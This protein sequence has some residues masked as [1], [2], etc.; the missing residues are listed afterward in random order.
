MIS[1]S[2]LIFWWMTILSLILLAGLWQGSAKAQWSGDPKVNTP[3]SRSSDQ[4]WN[5][6]I[7]SDG[8]DG[9]II[10]W[11]NY[12]GSG[13]KYNIKAQRLDAGG[14]IVWPLVTDICTANQDQKDYRVI[15]DGTGGAIVVWGDNRN[16]YP[17]GDIYA[18]RV[19]ASGQVIW[20]VDGVPI[21][22]AADV[23][24]YPDLC[25]DGAGGAIITW[26]DSR[27]YSSTGVDIYAQR[28]NASGVVQ[29][30]SN[31]IAV[32]TDSSVQMDPRIISDGSG[33]AIITWTDDRNS[34]T[35]RDI[36]AQKING[37]GVKQWTPNGVGYLAMT[38]QINP[39]IVSDGSGG[40]IIAWQDYYNGTEDID[41]RALRLTSSG[42]FAW[43][44]ANT[45]VCGSNGNQIGPLAVSDG[46]GGAIIVWTDYRNGTSNPDIY[47]DRIDVNG[48][49]KWAG[50]GKPVCTAVDRQISPDIVSD[51]FGGAIITWMDERSDTADIYA[52][53][54]D[55]NGTPQWTANGLAI[56][57]AKKAQN[58]PRLTRAGT[59][60]AIITWTDLRWVGDPFDDTD[61][62]IY[63]QRVYGNGTLAQERIIIDVPNG[64]ENWNVGSTR[65]IVW[66][67]LNFSDPI[68]IE[69]STDAG[70]NYTTIQPSCQNT[71]SFQWT[72]PN[73]PSTNCCVKISD[74]ADGNPFDIS[75]AVFTISAT[76]QDNTPVGTN[77]EV[78]LGSGV[79]ITFSQVIVAG[80]TTLN[81]N[82]SGPLPPE[83]HD[84][85]PIGS[86]LYYQIETTA[87]YT[88]DIYLNIFYNDTGIEP[89]LEPTLKL[90]K[91]I[92]T[93]A[94]W[95]NITTGI[96]EVMNVI[97]GRTDSLSVFAIMLPLGG[98]GETGTIVTNCD[99][100]G[101]GS[102]RDAIVF[103][104]NNPGPD[105]IRFQIPAGAPGH[106]S[107]IGVWMIVPQS[108]LPTITDCLLIDGFSQ[109]EFIGVDTNPHGPEIFLNGEIA[110]QYA[111]G[112]RSTAGGTEI[113][114]L[115]ISNF[116]NAGI[117]MYGVDGGRISG[118]YVGVDFAANGP[119]ANGYGIWLGNHTHHVT[120]SPYDTFK[121]VISGNTNGGVIVADTSNHIGILGNIIG[122]NRTGEYAIANGN[123]GGIRID[124]QCDSV[125]VFDNWIGGNKFGIY[126]IGSHFITIGNNFIGSNRIGDEILELGNEFD[127]IY[128]C[129][130]AHDN[131]ITENFIRFNSGCGVRI[132]GANT[133][134]NRV[135]HNHISGNAGS[136]ISN[137]SG[138]NLELAPPVIT[139][140]SATSVTGT[141]IPNAMV[142]I[143]TDPEDEGMRF[144]GETSS[145]VSGNFT[146][147]GGITGPFTNITA[148]AIDDQGNTSEF[149]SPFITGILVSA[150][151][152][153]GIPGDTITVPITVADITG[154]EI[155]GLS[156]TIE[157]QT[158]VLIPIGT[159][160]GGTIMEAWG[161]PT[162]QINGGQI[163]IAGA[164]SNPLSGSGILIIIQYQVNATA[165]TGQSTSIHFVDFMFN[166][167][168]PAANP[169]DGWFSIA[170]GFN[171]S[172]GIHYYN[173]NH[174][175]VNTILTIDG[176]Q[177]QTITDGTFSITQIPGGNYTLKPT[178]DGELGTC[179]SAF[180]A[181]MILRY[182]VGS[183]LLNP[184]QMS[185]AD[186]SG[187]GAV[188]AY[189]ASYILRYVVG[190]IIEFPVAD[191]WTF[192]P[193]DFLIDDTNWH[194]AP[195]SINYLPLNFDRIDQNFYGIIYG[196][197]S[198]NWTPAG[199][200]LTEILKSFS[201]SA[202]VQW[203]ELE[204]FSTE[205]FDIPILIDL[206]GELISIEFCVC[207]DP[208]I[209]EFKAVE[210]SNM[211]EN[212]NAEYH[213]EPGQLKVALAGAQSITSITEL[214]RIKFKI[215]EQKYL[216]ESIIELKEV[217]LNE[218]MITANIF[219][220]QFSFSHTLPTTLAL[221]QNYPNPFNP[222]TTI[223]FEI[224]FTGKQMVKVEL[225]IYNLQ[226]EL[227]RTLINEEKS[228][229]IYQA[230]WDGLNETGGQVAAGIY[231]CRI[232]VAELSAVRKMILVK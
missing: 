76:Q 166:E 190:S 224:P 140:V 206:K 231:L 26:R 77:V 230:H 202:N 117:G 92:E 67:N 155:Y 51:A 208:H 66:H 32:C 7:V 187:N 121:N 75:D 196:D 18:Q 228:P 163:T 116:Q 150:P 185:A 6:R 218:G 105:T 220:P 124:N 169:Q 102:L 175:I 109:S 53:R 99:D 164:G 143:Y 186:V 70:A 136:G 222:N 42:Q 120:I 115:T 48:A 55:A 183:L 194:T 62:D 144:Q 36:Y 69:Y 205:Q 81:I 112:L 134:R 173:N 148:L 10:V 74:A 23:Q 188:S 5:P 44:P 17:G 96:D 83:G 152:L 47:I 168:I 137:E 107:D 58:S 59:I 19:N 40:A 131:L 179:I 94:F 207:F 197:I 98:N 192:I 203:G 38:A 191:D 108:P 217:R 82:N 79:K 209:L 227:I 139:S 193:E 226:G 221:H 13:M 31:G 189:D 126:V 78:D 1:N 153:S 232:H 181:S 147:N 122:L 129:L 100:S 27:Y 135:S 57:T 14:N 211:M 170:S 157:T 87:A 4:E 111:H 16:E 64:G 73:T 25:S 128:L 114:G 214:A 146:W 149:S 225:R 101:P 72:V 159:S 198:G 142:E 104:N 15:S 106:D 178:K 151:N 63:A 91:Y 212:F 85:I 172:G 56:S 119:A 61:W 68:K 11:G 160:I 22:T 158:D 45:W 229:G 3:V 195:D 93:A 180:D 201:G 86:P 204:N 103:A 133:I 200:L 210:F 130:G 113:V 118:C 177:T 141:A 95:A 161:T 145:D 29:W 60:G 199:Q 176:Q 127:G 138:G 90:E 71:G 184:Y 223:Q 110:G 171:I 37:S 65:Y 215:T 162:T 123:Y 167:G 8:A 33:G 52:Q 24:A 182:V 165:Q 88:G 174:P 89:A 154:Q 125:A 216:S 156:F 54:F 84:I 213:L 28:I 30:T 21:C 35:A 43:T 34:T 132:E 46:A 20:T 39:T 12:A 97:E 49:S 9:A 80:N 219:N 41:I 50:W 2:K